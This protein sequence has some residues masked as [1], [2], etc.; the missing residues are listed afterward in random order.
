MIFDGGAFFHWGDIDYGGF[1]MLARLR[2][3][4][5]ADIQPWRMSMDELTRYAEF[6]VGYADVY[7]KRLLSLLEMPELS[8][9]FPCIEH[10]IKAG[11][12]LEQEAMLIT[13]K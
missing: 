11:V 4:I 6:T 5:M 10:M 9:C 1:L 8:D 2:R 13:D 7:E 3:E 12:R